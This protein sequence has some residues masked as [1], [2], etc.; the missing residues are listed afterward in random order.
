MSHPERSSHLPVAV[1]TEWLADHL[2]DVLVADVR[3]YLDGRSGRDAY[4]GGHLPGAVFVD[5]DTDL[6]APGTPEGGRHPLPSPEAFA[7]ALG[8]LGIGDD[9]AV[10]AYDD[11]G[12]SVAA[13]LV[14]MLRTL[15]SPAALLDGG[16]QS[17]TG[18]LPRDPVRPAPRPRTPV[19]WPADRVVDTAAVLAATA[20]DG[21]LLL[22][23]RTHGRFTGAQPAPV[24]ARPGHIP[25]ARSAF[26]QDNLGP[27]GR[28]APPERL[29]E[30]FEGLGAARA[31]T[32][33]AYCGSG[34]TACHDLLALE[35]AGFT[36]ARLYP[37]SWSAWG[38]DPDLPV[39]SGETSGQA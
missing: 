21:Q 27:D 39:E 6:A 32:V 11:A 1:S 2:D 36:G 20:D 19:A 9:T 13:R 34:V 28:F 18:A 14:W 16:I 8:A 7:V 17:W 30:R 29:R 37:G 33:T 5:V 38:A 4:L 25:G 12:G 22:D 23:A 31:G 24:D 10:V 15:G 3:W 35:L 26:W